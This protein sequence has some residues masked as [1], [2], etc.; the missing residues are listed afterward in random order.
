MSGY[1][2][3]SKSVVIVVM[4]KDLVAAQQL[5]TEAFRIQEEISKSETNPGKAAQ[6]AAD[7][8]RFRIL[9]AL[10]GEYSQI[11]DCPNGNQKDVAKVFREIISKREGA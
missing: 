4:R 11:P 1:Y 9:A 6:A 2:E 8:K 3:L 10:F 5:F 7:A